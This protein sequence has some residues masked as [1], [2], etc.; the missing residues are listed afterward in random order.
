MSKGIFEAIA[1]GEKPQSQEDRKH[2]DDIAKQERVVQY[3]KVSHLH[4]L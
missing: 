1:R 4:N 3:L 2:Q